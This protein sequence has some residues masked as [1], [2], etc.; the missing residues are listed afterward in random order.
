MLRV[1]CDTD[2][3]VLCSGIAGTST[4][5]VSLTGRD[6]IG[7]EIVEGL[8]STEIG[9]DGEELSLSSITASQNFSELFLLG[10]F[11]V[12]VAVAVYSPLDR[13]G[14]FLFG[15]SRTFPRQLQ[16]VRTVLSHP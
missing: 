3:G 11:Q 2:F 4:C 12:L 5:F 13:F 8:L 7:G 14:L 16:A 15:R 6:L 10:G 9:S 1:G